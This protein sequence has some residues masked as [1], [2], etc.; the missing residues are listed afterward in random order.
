MRFARHLGFAAA[1]AGGLT[2]SLAAA[3]VLAQEISDTH[4][5]AARAALSSMRAT[6]EFDEV[7][8]QA[9]QMIKSEL[10]QNNPD[11]Q[12]LIIQTVDETAISLAPRR[13]DL[14]REAAMAYARVFNEEDLTTIAEF[15]SSEA[16]QK[17]LNDGA[18]V[19]REVYSAANIWQNGITRD[20][21][22]QVVEQLSEELDEVTP[23][24]NLEMDELAPATE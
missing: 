1:L 7:L 10:I 11:Q 14:E 24:E 13:A 6:D 12:D 20:L 9:A 4:L 15:Y 5:R 8:P 21:A 18:I 2:A 17:L 3:P 19:A 16:G 23:P 22:A